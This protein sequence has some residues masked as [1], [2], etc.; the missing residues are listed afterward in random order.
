MARLDGARLRLWE[1]V[2]PAGRLPISAFPVVVVGFE[3][4]IGEGHY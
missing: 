1:Q 3:Y 2:G 4:A